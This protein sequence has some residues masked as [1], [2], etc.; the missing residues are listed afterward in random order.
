MPCRDG[1]GPRGRG[2]LTGHG[3][4]ECVLRE[5][6]TNPGYFKALLGSQGRYATLKIETRLLTDIDTTFAKRQKQ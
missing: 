5:L 1:R 4:G 3:G 6:K 2:P